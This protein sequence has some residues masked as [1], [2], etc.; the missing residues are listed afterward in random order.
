MK[1]QDKGMFYSSNFDK[2]EDALEYAKQMTKITGTYGQNYA[3]NHKVHCS[4]TA[5][6]F[7]VLGFVSMS[8]EEFNATDKAIRELFQQG[9]VV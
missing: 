1:T 3:R 9:T 8:V 5:P 7:R 6:Y 4:A 2:E